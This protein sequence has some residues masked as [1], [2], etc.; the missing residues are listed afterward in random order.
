M[1][2]SIGGCARA[3]RT[4]DA[5]ERLSGER[6]PRAHLHVPARQRSR[7]ELCCEQLAARR[8]CPEVDIL[9]WNDDVPRMPAEMHAFI[10]VPAT[11]G[12]NLRAGSLTLLAKRI[13]AGDIRTDTFILAAVEDHIVPW[14]SSYASTRLLS[15]DVWFGGSSA[16]HIAGIVNPPSPKSRYWINDGGTS[17]T[18]TPGGPALSCTRGRGGEEGTRWRRRAAAGNASHRRSK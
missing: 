3:P 17:S 12:T 11:C 1:R 9:A 5:P 15:G 6:R 7:L 16:G 13:G 4:D 10:C 2:S 18:R 8:A 14:T